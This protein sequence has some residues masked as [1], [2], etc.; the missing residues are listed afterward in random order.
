LRTKEN[1]K[2]NNKRLISA[3][4]FRAAIVSRNV[5]HGKKTHNKAYTDY[6]QARRKHRKSKTL[7][8]SRGF[9]SLLSRDLD[10]KYFDCPRNC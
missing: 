9:F 10:E 1:S 4:W 2:K 8:V 3:V 5:D 6:N 7:K